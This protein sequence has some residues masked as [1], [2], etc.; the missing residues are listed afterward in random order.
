MYVCVCMCVSDIDAG[1]ALQLLT[2]PGPYN[3]PSLE[4][5]VTRA[6]ST[7]VHLP[8]ESP[9]SDDQLNA[10]LLVCTVSLVIE[11]QLIFRTHS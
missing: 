3:L 9:I 8:E 1:R 2:H 5:V 11:F 4:N 7:L 6:T 10:I